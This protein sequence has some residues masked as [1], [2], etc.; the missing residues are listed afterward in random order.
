ML[1]FVI[2]GFVV[3]RSL[4]DDDWR[5]GRFLI[6]RAFRLLP[7]LLIYILA[8]DISSWVFGEASGWPFG[9]VPAS[10]MLIDSVT[11][12]TGTMS[13]Y[14]FYDKNVSVTMAHFWSLS[15]EDCFYL[16]LAALITLI[17]ILSALKIRRSETIRFT[18]GIITLF[19]AL[20]VIISRT[21]WAYCIAFEAGQGP[22]VIA[23]RLGGAP[24]VWLES[25]M[26]NWR[27]DFL[28]LSVSLFCLGPR[29]LK[30]RV[31]TLIPV[32]LLVA[33]FVAEAFRSGNGEVYLRAVTL[34]LT[35]VCFTMLIFLVGIGKARLPLPDTARNVLIWVGDRSYSM[36]LVHMLLICYGS[37]L[38][39]QFFIQ[40]TGYP[41]VFDTVT[42]FATLAVGSAVC[43]VLYRWVEL[44]AN[45]FGHRVAS[46]RGQL[47]PLAHMPTQSIG[48]SA[49]GE[50]G[51]Q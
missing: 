25:Y 48:Q 10:K 4:S 17:F 14:M 26:L 21:Y 16:F 35:L 32:F 41:I 39:Y 11:G 1:F 42:F 46:R 6:R 19:L 27:V 24:F 20:I 45:R 37:L 15:V 2:S 9:S 18:V 22:L 51:A 12:F 47:L 34:P 50:T 7:V 44:P 49:F 43:S 8:A 29:A 33:P 3:S 36:Y 5:A 28:F 23:K 40:I 38:A 31:G 13:I 30:L